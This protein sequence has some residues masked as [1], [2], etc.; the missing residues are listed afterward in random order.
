MEEMEQM[1]AAHERRSRD[2]APGGV[3]DPWLER[4]ACGVGLV[5]RASGVAGH[6]VLRLGLTAVARLAHRGAASSDHS[7]DG[8][9]ILTQ[10]PHRLLATEGGRLGLPLGGRPFAVGSLF[11]PPQEPALARAVALVG[12]TLK[13]EGLPLLGWRPVP[14][15]PHVLAPSARTTRPAVWQVFSA[16]PR[17]LREEDLG[18]SALPG[19]PRDRA[20]R[21]RGG[22][23]SGVRLLAVLPHHRV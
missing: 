19:A 13:A 20:A 15:A 7:G 9:G 11:L 21:R 23:R 2:R 3:P 16:R 22:T 8:A 1:N 14:V 4:D 10:I 17:A 5:A 6:D 18:G 12:D